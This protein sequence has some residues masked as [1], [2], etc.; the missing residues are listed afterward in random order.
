MKVICKTCKREY[1]KRGIKRHR[2][3]CLAPLVRERLES[4]SSLKNHQ[5]PIEKVME[6]SRLDSKVFESILQTTEGEIWAW[7]FGNRYLPQ[8]I[9]PPWKTLG[10]DGF[11]EEVTK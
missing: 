7:M 2:R 4:F 11:L 5:T 3:F 1:T 9:K 6:D 10:D 8:D